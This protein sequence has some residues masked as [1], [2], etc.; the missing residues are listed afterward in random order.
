MEA[1]LVPPTSQNQAAI[2]E[3]VRGAVSRRLR[4]GETTDAELASL[5]ERVIRNHDPC[6]SCSAHF[7]D[8]TV[9]RD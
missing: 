9:E 2:E 7:L 5:C 1:D 4:V 3:D 8:L 6:I